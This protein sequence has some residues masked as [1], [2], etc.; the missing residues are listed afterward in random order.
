[1]EQACGGRKS[2]TKHIRGLIMK[3]M[4]NLRRKIEDLGQLYI[5]GY[6]IERVEVYIRDLEAGY[7]EAHIN[8]AWRELKRNYREISGG[9]TTVE[10]YGNER[11]TIAYL[12]YY[13]FLNY[14]AMRWILLKNLENGTE[15]IP[16]KDLIKILDFGAGPGTA[17][18]AVCDF[19]EEAEESQIYGNTRVKLYF[20]EKYGFFSKC[21][22]KML[23]E[24]GMVESIE[25]VFDKGQ[26]WYKE[27]FYDL[28]ILS[29]VLSELD[30][31]IREWLLGNVQNCLRNGGYLA[32]IEPA[33]EGMRRYVGDFL[34]NEGIR[35]SFKVVDASG[36][37]CS[38][39]NCDQWGECYGKSIKRKELRT[40]DGM[41][42]EMKRFFEETKGGRTK[43]VYAVL[44]KVEGHEGFV[45]PSELTEYRE[46]RGKIIKLRGW[47]IK[48]IS[49]EGAENITL[50]N[51]LGR[52]NLAFWR[53]REDISQ[54]VRDISE[55]D[56]LCVKGESLEKSFSKLKLPSISVTEIVEHIKRVD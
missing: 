47:V 25:Y 33:Y 4:E 26:N 5:P 49:T 29:Y 3:E 43:W 15:I 10:L 22:R 11:R 42:E 27:N 31:T 54:R 46:R 30:N 41:T 56:I 28:I 40:A 35:R 50:C 48:K 32:I 52:C 20:D 13:F 14:P 2:K 17:S 39:Q 1:M 37:L 34:K 18:M 38:E 44:K 51:G 7:S 24:H 9:N 12:R 21:Y 16:R 36:P 53:N 45:D 19:L 8:D 55:G 6:V 23:S